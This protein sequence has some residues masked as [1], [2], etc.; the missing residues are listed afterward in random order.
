MPEMTTMKPAKVA[1]F[2][3]RGYNH[4]K[5]QK[6]IEDEEKEIARLEA[7]ARGEEVLEDD[8]EETESNGEG[9]ETT[10]VQTKSDSQQEEADTEDETQEDDSDL[11]AEEK[12]FKKRY[13]DLRRHMNQKEKEWEEKFEALK[14]RAETSNI[15]PPKS[16][17]DIEAWS[18][19]YPDVA[20]IVETIAA[21]KAKEMFASAE[22]KLKELDEARYEAQRVKAENTIR[23]S[24]AD[25]DELRQS[26][27]FHTWAEEQPKWVQDALYENADDPASVV[28]VIDL[29]KVDKG[30]TTSDKKAARKAA[31]STVKRGAKSKVDVEGTTGSIRE[32]E[33][34]KMSYK[35]F[36]ER[37][38]EINKAIR[39]GKFVYDLS[40][41]AR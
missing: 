16:D 20:G 9:S 6:R 27:E 13:G 10:E 11:T 32:S 26:D 2:V 21:K 4:E 24:H 18:K 25:F 15:S 39:N 40:G 8:E 34:A 30:L 22:D 31:A 36:E 14:N 17:E 5:K 38:D 23:K 19:Q 35:E 29:Y 41:S 7:L 12:S 3:D 37:E 28:R 1:G 33:V